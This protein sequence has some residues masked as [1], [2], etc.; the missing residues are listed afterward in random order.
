MNTTNTNLT[1]K[2][3]PLRA[4]GKELKVGDMVPSFVLTGTDMSDIS[5]KSL[6]GKIA[7]ISVVPSV[8]TPVCSLQ[9][10]R[11]NKEAG[12]FSDSVVILTVSMD[13]PFAQ[14]RWCGAEGVKSL[15]LGSDYKHRSFGNASGTVLP[16]LG[17]L[18]RSVF[19]A[20]KSGKIVYVEYVKELSDE[21]DYAPVLQKVRELL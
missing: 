11:F 13:L 2:G 16:D 6:N 10:K 4:E 21:P 20:D 8:D 3:N 5:E 12:E 14:S 17:L 9:T 1:F 7:I 19:V 15:T 18:A